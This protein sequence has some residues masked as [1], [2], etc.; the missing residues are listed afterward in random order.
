MADNLTPLPVKTKTDGDVAIDLAQYLGSA[1]GASNAIHIQ[2]GTG[3]TFVLASTTNT[4]EVVGDA[5]EN[6]A[7]AGNPVLSGG[8]FDASPRTLDDGDVGA[9]ALAA[10]GAV[11][12]DDGGNSITID[13]S[14]SISGTVD[15]ELPAA[16]A[17]ADDV[18]NP[19]V[20]AVGAYAVG[21]DSG[22]DNWNR[23]EVDDAGHLQVDV[24]SGA[25]ESIPTNPL[26]EDI[27]SASLAAGASV[28]LDSTDVGAA[29]QKL[30]Q[31]DIWASVP[32]KARIITVANA[33]ETIRTVLGGQALVPVIWTSPHKD[34]VQQ[35]PAGAG[36]DGFRVEMTNLDNV[37]AADV[38]CTF[39][40]EE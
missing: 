7:V 14:V 22:N 1:A 18:A 32:Y 38:Y 37:D 30:T 4:I 31:V 21:Y 40:T 29:T 20:P 6:A 17:L 28:D 36:F 35:G 12:I 3:A 13:G 26:V 15:T 34:Y 33:V 9:I 11:H 5:A 2:P 16:A 25:S 8:R 27:T 19:T 10:D 24:L 39:Y 23:V